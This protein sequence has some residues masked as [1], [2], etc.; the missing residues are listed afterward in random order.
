MAS[1]FRVDEKATQEISMT[2]VANGLLSRKHNPSEQLLV[3]PQILQILN[4]SEMGT[5]FLLECL[6]G[7][8]N[9]DYLLVDVDEKIHTEIL[10]KK[11]GLKDVKWINPAPDRF[12]RWFRM[13]VVTNVSSIKDEGRPEELSNY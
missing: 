13:N 3:E 11:E 6:K 12:Q 7:G 5:Y 2:Q 4:S 9:L 1:I 8:G 10:K